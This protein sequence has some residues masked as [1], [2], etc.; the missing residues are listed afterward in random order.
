[1]HWRPTRLWFRLRFRL[2]FPSSNKYFQFR[3]HLNCD[4]D[5]WCGAGLDVLLLVVGIHWQGH[6]LSDPR[7]FPED[8]FVSLEFQESADFLWQDHSVTRNG[9][10]DVLWLGVKTFRF[11]CTADSLDAVVLPSPDRVPAKL[12]DVVTCIFEDAIFNMAPVS[13]YLL[14]EKLFLVLADASDCVLALDCRPASTAHREP[15]R[16]RRDADGRC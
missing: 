7:V 4:H 9:S 15:G 1:M 2:R 11:H 10:D 6:G 8:G 12:P 3:G 13:A 5:A 16:G 14:Y